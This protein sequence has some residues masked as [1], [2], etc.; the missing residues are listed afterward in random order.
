[1]AQ[2]KTAKHRQSSSGKID[3][4]NVIVWFGIMPALGLLELWGVYELADHFDLIEP[5]VS[6]FEAER[7][8]PCG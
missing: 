7:P 3:W 4:G 8:T 1:M 5:I 6:F 2:V